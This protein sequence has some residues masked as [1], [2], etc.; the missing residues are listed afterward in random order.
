M[1]VSIKMCGG[2][3][4]GF[5]PWIEHFKLMIS[6]FKVWKSI[7]FTSFVITFLDIS[8]QTPLKN[9]SPSYKQLWVL[10]HLES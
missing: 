4:L 8:F 1:V 5:C 7:V 6:I 10:Y 9:P 3:D 2:I